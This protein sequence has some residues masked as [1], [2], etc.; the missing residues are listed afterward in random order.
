MSQIEK[1]RA[2]AAAGR[3]FQKHYNSLQSNRSRILAL[4]GALEDAEREILSLRNSAKG[5]PVLKKGDTVAFKSRKEGHEG[6]WY[7]GKVEHFGTE[8]I[9]IRINLPVSPQWHEDGD[10]TTAF[11]FDIEQIKLLEEAP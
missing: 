2:D 7:T 6:E 3:L 5:W 11:F 10:F 9:M 4:C 1:P 8:T